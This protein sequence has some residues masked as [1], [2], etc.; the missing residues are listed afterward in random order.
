MLLFNLRLTTTATTE[1]L[2]A[3]KLFNITPGHHRTQQGGS[4]DS[5]SF[6]SSLTTWFVSPPFSFRT[7]SPPLPT[8]YFGSLL[9]E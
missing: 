9:R 1:G 4:Q 7:H 2:Q 3:I 6:F 8:I 5:K